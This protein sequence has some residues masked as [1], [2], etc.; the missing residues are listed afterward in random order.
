MARAMARAAGA[1]LV[2]LRVMPVDVERPPMVDVASGSAHAL[3]DDPAFGTD[4]GLLRAAATQDADAATRLLQIEVDALTA[5]GLRARPRVAQGAVAEA[6]LDAAKAEQADLIAMSTH[7]RGGLGRFLLGSV[8]DRVAL[9]APVPV[10]LIRSGQPA[11]ELSPEGDARIRRILVPLDGSELA[12]S[13]LPGAAD[14]ARA[15][16]AQITLLRAMP[17]P[18]EAAA[19]AGSARVVMSMTD[20]M[21]AGT[22]RQRSEPIPDVYAA[23]V[24][25]EREAAQ[26]SLDLAAA[27]LLRQDLKVDSV[28]MFG[29]AAECI[30][31]V[32]RE[33]DVDL[34][35]IATHGRS[36]IRRFLAGSVAERIIRYSETPVCLW[37]ATA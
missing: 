30:L 20:S 35:A 11:R 4:Q 36:G 27:P 15:T 8:A 12:A 2:L 22:S 26:S 17:E 21:L 18:L 3:N 16:G 19:R 33:R 23:A 13:A 31:D 29:P 32:A 7:G 24:E 5:A 9:H 14:L 10:L 1:T 28:V 37:R 25:H 6:I 34:V